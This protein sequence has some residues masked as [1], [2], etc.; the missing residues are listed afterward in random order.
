M[1]TLF[2]GIFVGLGLGY[3][4]GYSD[5]LKGIREEIKSWGSILFDGQQYKRD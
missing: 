3:L 4:W 2:I 1:I 5:C